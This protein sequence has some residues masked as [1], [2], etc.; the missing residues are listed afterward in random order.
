MEVRFFCF[1]LF[2]YLFE[3]RLCSVAQAV[4]KLLQSSGVLTLHPL[5]MLLKLLIVVLYL[6]TG[7]C[8]A[9]QAVNWRP[10]NLSLPSGGKK[11]CATVHNL[12]IF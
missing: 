5:H 3:A 9:W 8:G 4:F 7:P 10:S 6:E 12:F 2:V 11:A 1:Y